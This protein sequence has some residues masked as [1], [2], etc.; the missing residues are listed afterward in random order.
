MFDKLISLI[1]KVLSLKYDT[2]QSNNAETIVGNIKTVIV[3]YVHDC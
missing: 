2:N 3:Q 1:T